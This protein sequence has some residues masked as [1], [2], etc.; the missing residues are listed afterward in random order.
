[1]VMEIEIKE[2]SMLRQRL[3]GLEIGRI[4]VSDPPNIVFSENSYFKNGRFRFRCTMVPND[5]QSQP[6]IDAEYEVL[7]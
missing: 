4:E 6:T 3:D 7:E 5:Q 2:F 1:M